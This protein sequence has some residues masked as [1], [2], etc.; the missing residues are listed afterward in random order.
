[1]KFGR[2]RHRA[3]F[4]VMFCRI[5]DE[6]KTLSGTNITYDNLRNNVIRIDF[7]HQVKYG[8]AIC[9]SDKIRCT[10]LVI[11]A[12]SNESRL[13]L[14]MR[15][16]KIRRCVKIHDTSEISDKVLDFILGVNIS[17]GLQKED[18]V[19][20][21]I[22][23]GDDEDKGFVQLDKGREDEIRNFMIESIEVIQ[24]ISAELAESIRAQQENYKL[25]KEKLQRLLAE[26]IEASKSVDNL[27][28]E[29]SRKLDNL[30]ERTDRVFEE[31]KEAYGLDDDDED[32]EFKSY[33]STEED[34]EA[35]RAKNVSTPTEVIAEHTRMNLLAKRNAGCRMF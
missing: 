15:Y 7:T 25:I 16:R 22:Y 24:N 20:G 8:D 4:R 14:K 31:E 5:I 27:F 28:D 11:C 18:S 3:A 13:F 9:L 21:E 2:S 10:L 19:A 17:K 33:L 34:F 12:Q 26:N 32:V 29:F 35:I 23:C 6:I 30:E 1:M